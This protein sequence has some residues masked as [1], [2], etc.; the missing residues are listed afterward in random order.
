MRA[1]PMR[2]SHPQ[3]IK[4]EAP[5]VREKV[6]MMMTVPVLMRRAC[7]LTQIHLSTSDSSYDTNLA[8]SSDSN[9][10]MMKALTL[11]LTLMVK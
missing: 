9:S 4:G 2:E 7:T 8:A 11:S 10:L 3:V 1:A 6:E 5:N